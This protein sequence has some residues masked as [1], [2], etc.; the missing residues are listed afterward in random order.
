M[1]LMF[2][3]FQKYFQF[4]GRSRRKEYWLFGLFIFI[5]A[6]VLSVFQIN[7]TPSSMG[8]SSFAQMITAVFNI[9]IIIPSLAVLSR[10][11]HDT[12]RSAWWMLLGLVPLIGT[13]VLLVFCCQN[14]TEGPN[15]FGSDP[16]ALNEEN[17]S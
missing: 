1:E 8:G 4:S 9:G 3:P 2:Q 16:K 10:R 14:G 5:V 11:L 13:I 7:S 12:D 17:N 15:R 6:I